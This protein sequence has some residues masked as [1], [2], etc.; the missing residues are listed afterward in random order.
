VTVWPVV[1]EA[2]ESVTV[3]VGA[4]SATTA[5]AVSTAPSAAPSFGVT[6]TETVWPRSPFPACERSSVA[7]VAP[8]TTAPS[9]FQT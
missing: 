1:G 7:P 8:G 4:L 5:E 6:S 2:G 9:T 3:A